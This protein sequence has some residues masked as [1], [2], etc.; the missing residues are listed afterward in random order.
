M[1]RRHFRVRFRLWST[2]VT[3]LELVIA[4]ATVAVLATM[5]VPA[6]ESHRERA[7][8]F[9]AVSDIGAM[10]LA[11]RAFAED[12]RAFPDTLEQV[13]LAG[14][15]DPWGRAYRYNN[16]TDEKG[17]GGARKDGRL[18]PLNSDFDLY[19]VGKDGETRLPLPPKVSHDDVV[20]ARN[21]RFIGLAK[22]FDP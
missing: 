20:R 16:L 8:V 10:G 4:M 5:A 9:Q 14:R 12:N 13:G 22:D 6:W 2:G 15:V 21:G 1:P 19:S 3:V 7:R 18:N 17:R 11:I